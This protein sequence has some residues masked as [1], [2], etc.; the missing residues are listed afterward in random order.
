MGFISENNIIVFI[1]S[2]LIIIYTYLL[3]SP[4]QPRLPDRPKSFVIKRSTREDFDIFM[5]EFR[6]VK[7]YSSYDWNS[8][9]SSNWNYTEEY[10]DQEEWGVSSQHDDFF[11]DEYKIK[12]SETKDN[13]KP[14]EPSDKFRCHYG[15]VSIR[16]ELNYKYLWMHS[17]VDM[18]MSATA[19]IDTPLHRKAFEIIPVNPSCDDGGW[20]LLR[21]ADTKGYLYMVAPNGEFDADEWTVKIGTDDRNATDNKYQF[22]LE[23]AGYV[24]NKGAMA[25]LSV[26]AQ[27]EYGIRGHTSGWDRTRAAG[28]EYSAA[29][30]FV[31]VN[32]SEV[33]AAIAKEKSE[34]KEAEE[35]DKELLTLIAGYPSSTEKRVISFGLYGAK[36]KYT[37]GAVTNAK[38]A[39]IYFPGW[40]CRYYVTSDVPE[41]IIDDLKQLGSEILPVPAGMGYS[42]GMFWRFMVAA[43][44]DVDR[45]IVRDVD[46]RL[47]ARDRVAV[48]EWINSRLPFHFLR[49]HVNHCLPINGGM[50][51]GLK[52]ALPHLKTQILAWKNR[53]EYSAD[54]HFLEEKVWPIAKDKQ[55]SHDSYCCDRYP[56]TKPYPSRRPPT[57][58]HVGQVFDG[59]DQPR[60]MDIDG[61]I[62]GVPIPVSCRKQADWIYG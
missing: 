36:D 25:F 24:L 37:L 8:Y 26:M 35:M 22:L 31:F 60:Y 38:L 43:D 49:D 14:N 18:W 39:K 19:T 40:V 53:D 3:V 1:L 15:W 51:G 32:A 5:N 16:S 56:N 7:N 52:G 27:S 11:L 62:R 48:E 6:S 55:I 44:D 50:W 28:R 12:S 30:H 21:E 41:K 58:Q 61:Y 45:Y 17:N 59:K 2:V 10:S 46:S 23:E 29:M 33:E 57:Y 47:N 42:S 9:K 34:V 20:V 54:L 4:T 13:Y